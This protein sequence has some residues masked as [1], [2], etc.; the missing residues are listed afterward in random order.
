MPLDVTQIEQLQE[1][2]K[3]AFTPGELE[4]L[5]L[6]KCSEKELADYR[7]DNDT[8]PSAILK[9]IQAAEREGWTADLLRAIAE[10]RPLREDIQTLVAQLR[11]QVEGSA[12]SEEAASPAAS[13]PST[14]P[15]RADA[16]GWLIRALRDPIWQ[17]IAGIIALIALVLA[18][19]GMGVPAAVVARLQATPTSAVALL[20]TRTSTPTLAPVSTV[21]SATVP[22]PSP[23]ITPTPIPSP[24]AMPTPTPTPTCP[25][26][27][28]SCLRLVLATDP[29]HLTC[30]AEN[31][32]VI[33][34]EPEDIR[35]MTDLQGYAADSE[36][37]A[38]TSGADRCACEWQGKIEA[39]P[40]APASPSQ[41]CGFSIGRSDGAPLDDVRSIYL[42]LTVDQQSRD[43]LITVSTPATR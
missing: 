12:G 21:A 18:V 7:T 19:I 27:Q 25:N 26:I 40:L 9:V 15:I 41:D 3:D 11:T 38:L 10:E 35:N 23:A 1:A 17:G 43:Y 8:Y 2:I 28:R 32:L 13:E 22:I 29:N 14:P 37:K 36:G 42:R 33:H 5:L 30:S 4:Q 6:F 34:I 24:T 20:P 31:P 39:A 16:T